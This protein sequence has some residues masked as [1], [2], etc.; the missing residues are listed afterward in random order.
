MPAPDL[1][2]R[3]PQAEAIPARDCFAPLAM[4]KYL[5]VLFALLVA[6]LL[7]GQRFGFVWAGGDGYV[8]TLSVF[9][10][11]ATGVVTVERNG[12]VRTIAVGDN[13]RIYR[14][15]TV[16]TAPG[17]FAQITISDFS[18]IVTVGMDERTTLTVDTLAVAKPELFLHGGRIETFM[19][20]TVDG[21]NVR[22]NFTRSKLGKGRASFVNY[23][24]KETVGIVPIVG[25]VTTTATK[26]DDT[27][28][29]ATAIGI[30]ETDPV[31][32]D[33]IGFNRDAESVRPF[34]DWIETRFGLEAFEIKR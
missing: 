8:S 32:F 14:G 9:L 16:M 23:D 12:V 5:T 34:Y 11:D 31:A 2:L 33:E 24:F 25:T 22:T 26:T 3:G 15:E 6:T 19:D 17:S 18:H 27:R 10:Q 30:H 13:D 20:G 21:L 7:V 1:S 28:T 4:T 29:T